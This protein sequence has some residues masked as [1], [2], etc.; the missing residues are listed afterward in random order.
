MVKDVPRIYGNWIIT[1]DKFGFYVSLSMVEKKMSNWKLT[2]TSRVVVVG[3]AMSSVVF[4]FNQTISAGI[5]LGVLFGAIHEQLSE[6]LYT[7]ILGQKRLNHMLFALF[8]LGNFGMLAMPL[9]IG[10]TSPD[11]VNV[12]G[13]AFGLVLHKI[14][15]YVE[16]FIRRKER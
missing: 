7:S 14:M 13:A 5:L 6:L 4:F 3:I 8:Y 12:F 9:Y 1:G 11:L 10:S 15:I 2:R 16:V